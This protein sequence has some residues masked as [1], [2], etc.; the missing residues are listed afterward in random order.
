MSSPENPGRFRA[1]LEANRESLIDDGQTA[2]RFPA[3][4]WLERRLGHLY[5][6][7][8][9]QIA[10][11]RRWDSLGRL[12]PNHWEQRA[13]VGARRHDPDT[14]RLDLDPEDAERLANGREKLLDLKLRILRRAE[15]ALRAESVEGFWDDCRAELGKSLSRAEAD[16]YL[17]QDRVYRDVDARAKH[18]AGPEPGVAGSMT[19]PGGLSDI[20][21]VVGHFECELRFGV[22]HHTKRDLLAAAE[23]LQLPA[24]RA[25]LGESYLAMIERPWRAA[26]D[27][28]LRRY[29]A[30]ET[31]PRP[32]RF[33]TDYRMRVDRTIADELEHDVVFRTTIPRRDREQY[34]AYIQATGEVAKSIL[35][36]GGSLPE[37]ELPDPRQGRPPAENTIRRKGRWWEIRFAGVSIPLQG[38]VGHA[39][40]AHLIEG[41]GRELWGWE[42]MLLLDPPPSPASEG[43]EGPEVP[44]EAPEYGDDSLPVLEDTTTETVQ[45]GIRVLRAR[46]AQKEAAGDSRGLARMKAELA[47]LK[48]YLMKSTDVRGRTRATGGR[49]SR[50]NKSVRSAIDYAIK[51]LMKEH[52]GLAAHLDRSIR[53]R[54]PFSYHPES[55]PI[56]P[57]YS[58][59]IGLP[60]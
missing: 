52:S 3:C 41:Q 21:D 5:Y 48:S 20:L 43:D 49:R 36:S 56:H 26:I 31:D 4:P 57:A 46:V 17:R 23:Q 9:P 25:V 40:M 58:R 38:L 51:K 11:E 7:K 24:W 54:G 19:L 14:G 44:V 1:H 33:W 30:R 13:A 37:F 35:A 32:W 55:S 22:M 50:A 16:F 45:R 6:L 34:V 39:Y 53:R 18:V 42:L 29:A 8:L 27:E 12:R 59:A 60:S 2:A 10:P 15:R 47:D 28:V